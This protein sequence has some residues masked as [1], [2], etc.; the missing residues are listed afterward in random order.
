ML[1]ILQCAFNDS[2]PRL[3]PQFLVL[4]RDKILRHWFMILKALKP[5]ETWE[6][7]G[8]L[9]FYDHGFNVVLKRNRAKN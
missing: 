7:I 5:K 1:K 4:T 6:N 2:K 3:E 8:L 9:G